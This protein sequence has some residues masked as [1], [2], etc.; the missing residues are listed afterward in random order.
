MPG[1][2]RGWGWDRLGRHTRDS[3]WVIQ[4]AYKK[5]VVLV[6]CVY[7]FLKTHQI[8]YLKWVHFIVC[9]V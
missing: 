1:D 3:L 4:R 8:I 2:G 6:T 7:T 9:K 5:I